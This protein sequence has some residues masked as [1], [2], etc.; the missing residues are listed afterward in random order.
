MGVL[1]EDA[2]IIVHKFRPVK[3]VLLLFDFLFTIKFVYSRRTVLFLIVKCEIHETITLF[4]RQ[5]Q[6]TKDGI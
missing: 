1:T 6:P 2:T 3:V 5:F 4:I